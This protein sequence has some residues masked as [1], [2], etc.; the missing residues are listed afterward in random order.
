MSASTLVSEGK[1]WINEPYVDLGTNSYYYPWRAVH[2]SP[3]LSEVDD[4]DEEAEGELST[5]GVLL[6]AIVASITI[7]VVEYCVAWSMK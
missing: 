7:V 4:T 2:D 3:P 6:G 5:V 1:N